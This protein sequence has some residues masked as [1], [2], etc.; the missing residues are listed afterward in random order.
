MSLLGR[1]KNLRISSHR[2]AVRRVF[3]PSRRGTMLHRAHITGW[4]MIVAELYQQ[5]SPP[6]LNGEARRS[7]A[8]IGPG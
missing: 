7:E 6:I 8:L 3:L 1:R 4:A 5:V 2:I